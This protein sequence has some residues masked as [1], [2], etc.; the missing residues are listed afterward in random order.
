MNTKKVTRSILTALGPLE[1]DEI[2]TQ[3][4]KDFNEAQVR[5]KE[6]PL[7]VSQ[8]KANI[9]KLFEAHD[10]A[11]DQIRN[12]RAERETPC[13]DQYDYELGMIFTIRDDGTGEKVDERRMSEA[14]RQTELL[15]EDTES[16]PETP[17]DA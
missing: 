13:L 3:A 1:I 17:A 10:R 16:E 14:E 5:K 6:L 4:A 11:Q 9:D 2:A 15:P 8:E 12:R 7:Y